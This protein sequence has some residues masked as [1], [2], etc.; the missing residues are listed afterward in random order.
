MQIEFDSEKHIWRCEDFQQ[1]MDRF[2]QTLSEKNGRL[3]VI[4]DFDRCK[5]QLPAYLAVWN[6]HLSKERKLPADL[7]YE[8][9]SFRLYRGRWAIL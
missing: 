9:D 5:H 1:K 4:T 6:E 7:V 2:C 3:M 8:Q